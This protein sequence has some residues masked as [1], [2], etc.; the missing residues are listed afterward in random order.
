MLTGE[1]VTCLVHLTLKV[2]QIHDIISMEF[3][4]FE[5]EENLLHSSDDSVAFPVNPV[6][7]LLRYTRIL[8][9]LHVYTFNAR[10]IYV[11]VLTWR[12]LKVVRSVNF[13]YVLV[14]D[15]QQISAHWWTHYVQ[16]STIYI[17]E[18][19]TS[20]Y[21]LFFFNSTNL[22]TA[23]FVLRLSY[24]SSSYKIQTLMCYC[25]CFTSKG[26]EDCVFMWWSPRWEYQ[27]KSWRMC[28]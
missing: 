16:S 22:C 27:I 1:E 14:R 13:S 26:E 10:F 11:S 4:I 18:N 21:N 8:F 23:M 17:H 7:F 25:I 6:V 28:Y 2:S 5:V 15:R 19:L 9:Y 3:P 24:T 20:T 12:S